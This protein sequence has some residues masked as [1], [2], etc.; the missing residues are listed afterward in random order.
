MLGKTDER[1]EGDTRA[2]DGWTSITNSM[3]E[4]TG[5]GVG[6]GLWRLWSV[7]QFNIPKQWD[8]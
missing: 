7:V 6:D 8:C 1:G 2:P 5:S 3:D 4:P